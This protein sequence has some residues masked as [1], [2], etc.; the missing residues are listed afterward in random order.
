MAYITLVY[1]MEVD[2]ERMVAEFD[3]QLDFVVAVIPPCL[4]G[5]EQT[6]EEGGEAAAD[7][8]GICV[9]CRKATDDEVTAYFWERGEECDPTSTSIDD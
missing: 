6:D 4:P 1:V 2:D 3:E 7:I 9:E 8:E 5:I